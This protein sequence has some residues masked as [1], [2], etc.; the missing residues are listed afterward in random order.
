M[1]LSLYGVFRAY[2]LC[3]WVFISLFLKS[4]LKWGLMTCFLYRLVTILYFLY[5]SGVYSRI[6]FSNSFLLI[7]FDIA[8]SILFYFFYPYKRLYKVLPSI[9]SLSFLACLLRQNL[10]LS[11]TG[12]RYTIICFAEA[13]SFTAEVILFYFY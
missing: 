10:S 4:I 12:G 6:L 13:V 3:D 9:L 2:I 11:S 7:I 1:I 5:S 8:I